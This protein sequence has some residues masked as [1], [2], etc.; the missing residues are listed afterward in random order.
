VVASVSAAWQAARRLGLPVVVKPQS[1]DGGEQVHVRLVTQQEV[2]QAAT[3]VIDAGHSVLVEVWKPGR[4]Y[5]LQV[6][7]DTIFRCIERTPGGVV[8]DGIHSIASL[9][10]QL[11]RQPDRGP[12]GSGKHRRTI[13]LDLEAERTL[14]Q[15]GIAIDSVPPAGQF[16][17]LRG[18][19]NVAR[20]GEM[21]S[22]L[23]QAH[24]D[25]LDLAVRA[26]AAMRL[27]LA[28]VDILMSDIRR[29]W[30]D[31][32][33]VICEVNAQPQM[34]T[35]HEL[36]L[37]GLLNG[38]GRIPIDVVVGLERLGPR[39]GLDPAWVFASTSPGTGL[40][41]VCRDGVF[42][43]GCCYDREPNDQF[44][45]IS[46]LLA[47]T[48]VTRLVIA[49]WQTSLFS[50]GLPFDRFDRLISLASPAEAVVAQDAGAARNTQALVVLLS[51]MARQCLVFD[52]EEALINSLVEAP[53]CQQSIGKAIPEA[54]HQCASI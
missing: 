6:F 16:V 3:A 26:A 11:N 12:Q 21:H 33:A 54:V 29:S 39:L 13:D 1:A 50:D 32:G 44:A 20:G 45:A 37:Q 23:D 7:R 19:A 9:L 41:L 47:C 8:G 22:V 51:Q 30:L 52:T 4:D 25:N 17:A 5:R 28:G 14:A 18:A 43:D 42:V 24:P 48:R 36:V 53:P 15:Q 49:V 38:D 35:H 2:E 46:T 31:V 34:A 40:G 27:D 10:E